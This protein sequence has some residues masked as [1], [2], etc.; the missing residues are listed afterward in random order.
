MLRDVRFEPTEGAL[1]YHYC[2]PATLHAIIQNKTIRLADISQMNDSM[3]LQW[4]LDLLGVE[5]ER[6]SDLTEGAKYLLERAM[7]HVQNGAVCL[8]SCLSTQGD[9]LSQWRAYADNGAGFSVGFEAESFETL[10]VTMFEVC[11][12]PASQRERV[13][14]MVSKIIEMDLHLGDESA[15]ELLFGPLAELLGIAEND[16]G[17]NLASLDAV[18]QRRLYIMERAS[19]YGTYD[20][21]AF[22]NPAFSE[23]SE[24]RVV[25]LARVNDDADLRVT[26]LGM[27]ADWH[28]KRI[29]ELRFA[30]RGSSPICYLDA[31]FPAEMIKEVVIGPR[32]Q[33]TEVALQRFLATSGF[34]DV[35][36][37]RSVAS[38]R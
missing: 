3:E 13:S 18:T 9:V 19:L 26:L 7:Q 21:A 34:P 37:R 24:V 38:Y 8:A 35:T 28:S 11:Y 23:E 32:A 12:D 10:P 31:P 14:E 16:E 36:V 20:L 22:K 2:S 15:D 1:L 4:G 27:D 5:V 25:H 6:R 17:E 30:M 33:V 29:P